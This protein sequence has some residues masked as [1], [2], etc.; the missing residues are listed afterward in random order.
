MFPYT[1]LQSAWREI[2]KDVLKSEINLES[3]S[4][5]R[6][7]LFAHLVYNRAHEIQNFGYSCVWVIKFLRLVNFFPA[8]PYKPSTQ[9]CKIE[10]LFPWVSCNGK[11]M[12][13]GKRILRTYLT[14]YCIFYFPILMQGAHF[15]RKNKFLVIV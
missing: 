3:L 1:L 13:V 5:I 7:L 9:T 4:Y 10:E 6:A 11:I 14:H 15:H 12:P 2:Y 8:L